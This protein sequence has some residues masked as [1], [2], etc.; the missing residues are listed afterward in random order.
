MNEIKEIPEEE[1]DEY[2]KGLD[3]SEQDQLDAEEMMAQNDMPLPEPGMGGI[4]SLFGKVIDKENVVRLANLDSQELGIL[5]F[6]VRGCLLVAKQANTFEHPVFAKYFADQ[7]GIIL[8]TSFSKGG[9]FTELFVTSKKYATNKD[10]P[11]THLPEQG[12][13]K[14]K[15]WKGMFSKK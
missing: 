2:G 3:S 10:E 4:F 5:T 7:A 9:W 15:K 14:Q 1:F 11:K 12:S 13:Q 8:D 6:T